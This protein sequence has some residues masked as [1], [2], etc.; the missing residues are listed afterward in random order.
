M[1]L[2]W[3]ALQ[4]LMTDYHITVGQKVAENWHLPEQVKV[5]IIYYRDYANHQEDSLMKGAM[6]T[7]LAD[8][9]ATDLLDS[10]SG[11]QES[12]TEHPVIQDLNLY[13]EDMDALFAQGEPILKT[14]D[15]MAV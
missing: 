5:A 11:D 2:A 14:V 13:P 12:I 3:E 1:S 8:Q 6:I 4:L 15:S 7:C 9:F 10:N